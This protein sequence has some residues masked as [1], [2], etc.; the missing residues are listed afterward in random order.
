MSELERL[1]AEALY[2][3]VRPLED[4]RSIVRDAASGRLFFKKRLMTYNT[5]VFAWL[6]AHRSRYVPRIEAFW[7]EGPELVVIEEMIQGDTLEQVLTQGEGPS[8]EE[9]VRILM[10]ICDGLSFLH[11]AEPPIIHRDLKASNIMLTEDGVVKIIDYDAAK[12]SVKGQARDTQL[13]GTQGNAA[14]EQYGFAASDARTDIFALGKLIGR[15]L[16]GNADAMRIAARATRM[17][18]AK[19]YASAAQIREPIR[20]IREHPSGLDSLLEK[21]PGYDPVSRRQR[22]LARVVIFLLFLALA[23]GAFLTYR[24][25]VV[26]PRRQEEAVAGAVR[27]LEESTE[28]AEMA[29]KT[30]ALL[31][32]CP[33]SA[34]T[35]DQQLLVRDKARTVVRDYS[36]GTEGEKQKTGV[37]LTGDGV[38]FISRIREMGVDEAAAEAISVGGQIRYMLRYNDWEGA[39]RSLTYLEG[40]PDEAALRERVRATSENAANEHKEAFE[41]NGTV[42][43]AFQ[44]M[45]LYGRMIDAGFEEERE[46]FEAYYE[47]LIASAGTEQEAEDFDTAEKILRNLLSYEA[48]VSRPQGEPALADRIRENDYLR[49]SWKLRKQDYTEARAAFEALGDYRDSADRVT[50][51]DYLRAKLLHSRKQYKAAAELFGKISGYQDAD[52]LCREAKFQYCVSMEEE[53]DETTYT[54]IEE[55]A[56]ADYPGA[57]ALRDELCTWNAVIESGINYRLGAEQSAIVRATLNHGPAKGS[58]HLRF[59]I[60]DLENGMHS[61]FTSEEK[62][63]RG[64]SFSIYYSVSSLTENIFEKKYRVEIYADDG[65][66]IG[67][68]SGQFTADFL[69][70]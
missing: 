33:Y 17:D 64:E 46:A 15:M 20:R 54:Y 32:L 13:I 16:P 43:E 11:S 39:F 67:S 29:E 44:A 59:E 23:G 9:R 18:P 12:I 36:S 25:T 62:V 5:E 22:V 49:A 7:Q 69:R 61:S 8:F 38:D 1:C 53:P 51:C 30:L 41:A 37:C 60:T 63:S 24:Q 57:S 56:R 35:P 66:K 31:E 34:L 27:A 45:W 48:R 42:T 65:A 2:E 6:K 58:T 10:E 70:D 26:L 52:D 19:R 28:T 68:W 50:E 14:P 47:E 3:E 21:L 4:G 40:L 55:L